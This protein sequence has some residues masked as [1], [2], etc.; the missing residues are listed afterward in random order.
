[1]FEGL[2][3]WCSNP[4]PA[5]QKPKHGLEHQF[6]KPSNILPPLTKLTRES[7]RH[8]PSESLAWMSQLPRESATFAELEKLMT[9]DD[10]RF[11][12]DDDT[13]SFEAMEKRMKT[14]SKGKIGANISKLAQENKENMNSLALE[15]NSKLLTEVAP[16]KE[17][18]ASTTSTKPKPY[19]KK[20][21][22][23]GTNP[24]VGSS[25][26]DL[27]P[28]EVD[29]SIK[30]TSAPNTPIKT[31]APLSPLHTSAPQT[32]T[33][34]QPT[35]LLGT[36]LT[37]GLKSLSTTDISGTVMAQTVQVARSASVANMAEVVSFSDLVEGLLENLNEYQDQLN[38]FREEQ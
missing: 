8:I 5:P 34:S 26:T 30:A 28:A 31:S 35:P 29:N 11:A 7:F 10:K 24:S 22:F 13:D 2:T 1:M 21:E 12:N 18:K 17:I 6:A 4:V 9:D 16:S 20:H 36:Q 25:L 38:K 19:K 32:S 33:L 23:Y 14:P 27:S 3:N 15:I 37:P